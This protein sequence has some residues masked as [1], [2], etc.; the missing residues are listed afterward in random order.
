[1][2]TF[3]DLLRSYDLNPEDVRLVRHGNKEIRVQSLFNE[4]KEKFTAY[5]AWQPANKYGKAKY[6]A[7]FA[8]ARG[9]TSLFLGLWSVDGVTPNAQLKRQHL[10]TLKHYKLPEGWSNKSDYYHLSLTKLMGD[11][12]QRLVIEWGGSTL[13]WVQIKDKNVVEIKPKNS[14]GEFRSY[15]EVKLT[16]Q[17]IKKLAKDSDSNSVW[18]SALSSVN[19]VYLIRN[20]HNGKLYVGSAYGKGGILARWHNYS[21]SGHGGNQ[22]LKEL[23]PGALE[24]SILEIAPS[25]MS[26]DDLIAREQGWKSKLGTRKFGLNKN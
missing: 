14:I 17:D 24:F 9:T 6:L 13:K 2:L 21:K 12:S 8:P 20:K 3:F 18:V 1:M 5:T 11:L 22:R 4:D 25:T 23:D 26:N 16:Y 19:G 15:S 10:A 7:I